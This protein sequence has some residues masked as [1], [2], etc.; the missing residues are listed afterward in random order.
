[1]PRTCSPSSGLTWL[2]TWLTSLRMGAVW[3][4]LLSK[5]FSSCFSL[6]NLYFDFFHIFYYRKLP[7]FHSLLFYLHPFIS[8][9]FLLSVLVFWNSPSDFLLNSTSHTHAHAYTH[10]PHLPSPWMRKLGEKIYI[11]ISK[12]SFTPPWNTITLEFLFSLKT[13]VGRKHE[14]LWWF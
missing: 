10:P 14:C 9:H 4:N 11:G 1:M 2:P 8:S 6:S 13:W 12:F 7:P 5:H 3:K